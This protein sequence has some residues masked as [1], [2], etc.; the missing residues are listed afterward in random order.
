M[1]KVIT[2]LIYVIKEQQM[3]ILGE[4]WY[5]E[6]K[7]RKCLSYPKRTKSGFQNVPKLLFI[8]F[9]RPIFPC[10][11]YSSSLEEMC[12]STSGE[13]EWLY[14]WPG[15]IAGFHKPKLWRRNYYPRQPSATSTERAVKTNSFEEADI[16]ILEKQGI[17]MKRDQRKKWRYRSQSHMSTCLTSG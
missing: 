5:I 13:G 8:L 15:A 7:N 6:E 16:L 3:V 11:L 12:L 1:I 2:G 10:L 9:L 4:R 17:R 14:N